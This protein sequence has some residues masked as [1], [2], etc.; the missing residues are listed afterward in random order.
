MSAIPFQRNVG[1][2]VFRLEK[3]LPRSGEAV[4]CDS[5]MP[6]VYGLDVDA[7]TAGC[8][9]DDLECE[10]SVTAS[11]GLSDGKQVG[12]VVQDSDDGETYEDLPASIAW[13][14]AGA[15]GNGSPSR[16]VRF[17]LPPDVRRFV[18]VRMSADADAGDPTA[19]WCTFQLL[20]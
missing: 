18:A 14:I 15:D 8:S 4:Y 17:R 19:G 6:D 1:D 3:A 11:P 16:Y 10:F 5:S 2:G 13:T 20:F 7:I 9:R 12:F